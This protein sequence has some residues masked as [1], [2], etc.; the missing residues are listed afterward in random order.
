MECPNCLT[1]EFLVNFACL[2]EKAGFVEIEANCQYQAHLP[3]YLSVLQHSGKAFPCA[4]I[5]CFDHHF[6]VDKASTT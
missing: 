6:G 1:F 5:C 4:A 2:M 3:Q